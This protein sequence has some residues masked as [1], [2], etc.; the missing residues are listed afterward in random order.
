MKD[1]T[2]CLWVLEYDI[3]SL[4]PKCAS[5]LRSAVNKAEGGKFW[6]GK[7]LAWRFC[8]DP[9]LT[10]EPRSSF[11]FCS[12]LEVPCLIATCLS[13]YE[14]ARC[15]EPR[16]TANLK[17]AAVWRTEWMG[18]DWNDRHSQTCNAAAQQSGGAIETGR[19]ISENLD[20]D[21]KI[22]LISSDCASRTI[23]REEM[24]GDMGFATAHPGRQVIATVTDGPWK[25][26]QPERPRYGNEGNSI[27]SRAGTGFTFPAA[28]NLER[29]GRDKNLK[30]EKE[31]SSM[32]RGSPDSERANIRESF[33]ASGDRL[34]SSGRVALEYNAIVQPELIGRL[35]IVHPSVRTSVPLF[36]A[37]RLSS[38]PPARTSQKASMALPNS[39]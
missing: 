9:E 8:H 20:K 26:S 2:V 5:Y 17:R 38:I 12:L 18:L 25:G 33:Q 37:W 13:E 31:E 10:F 3:R 21:F 7:L 22:C 6:K 39:L 32:G 19:H 34:D 11:E 28:L 29:N 23:R 36:I 24:A 27:S 14:P 4:A 16:A 15:A 1:A 35:A 30:E